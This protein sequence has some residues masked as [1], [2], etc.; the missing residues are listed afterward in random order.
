MPRFFVENIIS[1][2]VVIVGEDARHISKVLRM[3]P[4]K[5]LTVSDTR[6]TDYRCVIEM[7]S[8]EEVALRV[9]AQIPCQSESPVFVRLYQAL[10][11]ADKLEMIVQKAV[12]LGASE[13]VP[14]LTSRCISRPSD[15]AMEKKRMR[16]QKI[17]YAA[18]KQAGRGVVP[19][20]QPLLGFERAVEQMSGNDLTV[21]LYENSETPLRAVLSAAPGGPASA[22]LL[23]G[24]EGGFSPAEAE[25]ARAAGIPHASLG[26]RILRC[27]TAPV[28]ALS[29]LFYHLGEF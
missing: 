4:G 11:K 25:L 2:R 23:V 24:S 19:Q 15:K 28:C 17:A 20:I 13:I 6:G 12:E 21:M 10:P 29:V 18:A 27:E 14:V 5:E 7:L 26:P 1:D 9:V 8:A 16:L 3:E 22:A